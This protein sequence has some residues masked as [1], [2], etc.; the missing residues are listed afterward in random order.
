[1]RLWSGRIR[2]L[3]TLQALK[4]WTALQFNEL[5]SHFATR[6]HTNRWIRRWTHWH[7]VGNVKLIV[8]CKC[9]MQV[10]R[11]FPVY[12]IGL[13][14]TSRMNKDEADTSPQIIAQ[15][16]WGTK[17]ECTR[18]KVSGNKFPS[19]PSHNKSGSMSKRCTEAVEDKSKY[20]HNLLPYQYYSTSTSNAIYNELHT[21]SN[22]NNIQYLLPMLFTIMNNIHNLTPMLFTIYFQYC[23]PWTTCII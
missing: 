23:Q 19:H 22:T 8:M 13:S 7:T 3:W 18:R 2:Y 12:K 21:Q 20:M 9:N 4:Q 10:M 5:P 16:V 6:R 11:R 17:T 14:C 1:M 15:K